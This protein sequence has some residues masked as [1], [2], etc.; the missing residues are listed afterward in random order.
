[1]DMDQIR[2][3]VAIARTR[4]FSRA[5][6]VLHRSQPAIS[7]RVSLLTRELG[8]PLFERAGGQITLSEAGGALLPYAETILAAAQDGLEAVRTLDRGDSGRLALA[9][10]GT[11]ANA[12][13]TEMLRRFRRQHPGVHVDVETANSQEVGEIVRRGDATLGLRYMHDP[14][15]DLVSETVEREKLVVVCSPEHKLAGCRTVRPQQLAGERWVAFRTAGAKE[16]FVQFLNRTLAVA[17][18]HEPEVTF[19]DSLTAQKRLVEANFGIALLAES[20]VEEE[21][22]AGTLKK[23]NVPALRASI[24]VTVVYRK[25]GYLSGAARFFLSTVLSRRMLREKGILRIG[26]RMLAHNI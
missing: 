1:M 19:I 9:I 11:L 7:R 16:T 18:L 14:S 13:F 2:T 15:R 24:P 4:N 5:A 12:T 17:G 26:N 20:G 22:K 6:E 8:I 21:T 23:L 25:N 3:F 10:V